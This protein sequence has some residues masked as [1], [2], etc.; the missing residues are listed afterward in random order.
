MAGLS[1]KGRDA[2]FCANRAAEAGLEEDATNAAAGTA[3]ARRA[4]NCM[5]VVGR[6][7]GR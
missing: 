4:T 7:D 3:R 5:V 2:D 1:R 6:G